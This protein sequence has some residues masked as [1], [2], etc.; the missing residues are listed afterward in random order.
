MQES[1]VTSSRDVVFYGA[2]QTTSTNVR[3]SSL[4]ERCMEVLSAACALSPG[5]A[6]NMIQCEIINQ[7]LV[8]WWR[9]VVQKKVQLLHR[10]TIDSQ[11]FVRFCLGQMLT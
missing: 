2:V 8:L 7:S 4:C 5:I 11:T 6:I 10:E 9:L 3:E 1:R